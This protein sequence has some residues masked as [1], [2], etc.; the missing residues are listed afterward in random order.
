[1]CT[2]T[3]VAADAAQQGTRAAASAAAAMDAWR[4][5]TGIV[6]SSRD[7]GQQPDGDAVRESPGKL[8]PRARD[9]G[10]RLLPPVFML[11]LLAPVRTRKPTVG[12]TCGG[13]IG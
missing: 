5:R 8:C 3:S 2:A 11:P 13:G 1:M 7:C 10:E 9:G 12:A 4:S 6:C